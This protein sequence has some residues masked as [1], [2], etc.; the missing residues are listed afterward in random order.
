MFAGEGTFS[1]AGLVGLLKDPDPIIRIHAGLVLASLGDLAR[2]A[3]PARFACST[4]AHPGEEAGGNGAGRTG[5]VARSAAAALFRISQDAEP[6]LPSCSATWAYD[7]LSS[8]RRVGG[9]VELLGGTP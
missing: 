2:P 7:Q 6:R 1:V 3:V 4:S 9:R 5:R 8:T